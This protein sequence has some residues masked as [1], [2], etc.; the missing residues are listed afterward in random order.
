MPSKVISPTIDQDMKARGIAQVMVVLAGPAATANAG[1]AAATT[2]S[3]ATRTRVDA[4]ARRVERHFRTSERSQSSALRQEIVTRS[5]A[6][7]AIP[8]QQA[9]ITFPNLGVMLGTVDRDG[10]AGLQASNDVATVCGTPQLSLIR[11]RNIAT[12]SGPQIRVT[13]GI[14]Q[15][16]VPTLW[17][18]GLS[19][20]GIRIA[21]LDT[22]VDPRHPA[23][24]DA[25]ADFAEFELSLG[26]RIQNP[27]PHDSGDHGTHTA[28][29]IAG[30][31]LSGRHIGVAHQAA[32]HSGLVIEGGNVVARVLGGLD[33]AIESGVKII[34]MSLGFA[35]WWE[36][37]IPIIQIIRSHGILPII[38][39]GNEGP[40]TSRSP[41][42]YPEVLSVGASDD[43]PTVVPFSSSQGFARVDSPL[44]P[45]L[46]AP[47]V[48]IISAAP[49]KAYQSMSGTS[50]ATPHI[51]GLAA[52]LWEA[53]SSATANEIENALFGSCS[54]SGHLTQD[55]ASRG[56]PNAVRALERLTGTTLGTSKAK[57]SAKPKAKPA[58]KAKGAATSK[59][60]GKKGAAKTRK[61]AAPKTKSKRKRG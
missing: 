48:D 12:A 1:L 2:R 24:K 13:W 43:V 14:E 26:Q 56:L 23:L 55:R 52:L 9:C 58:A 59:A 18:E 4:E 16:G 53:K 35:G 27:T 30:R 32:L 21:H 3:A 37:F 54:L 39:V 7:A 11:P 29:T 38:A 42:N 22:G 20:K 51:A 19:G 15:L 31:P 8:P 50:M 25:I 40:G 28:G 46:V 6:G 5:S 49:G 60:A 57:V 47:G 34:S 41:G 17:K 45:D 10:L 61:A 36:E 33:W 44:V